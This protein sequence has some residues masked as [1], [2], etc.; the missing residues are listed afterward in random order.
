MSKKLPK[1]LRPGKGNWG[2]LWY[3]TFPHQDP[4][5]I[6]SK[7]R[8]RTPLGA[9][10]RYAKSKGDRLGEARDGGIFEIRCMATVWGKRGE[11]RMCTGKME[12]KVS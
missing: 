3:I 5:L 11:Q 7:V 6:M 9:A 10:R 2:R 12:I 4:M 8:A 1:W